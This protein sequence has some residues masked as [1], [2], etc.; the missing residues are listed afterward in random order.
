MKLKQLKWPGLLIAFALGNSP[1]FAAENPNSSSVDKPVQSAIKNPPGQSVTGIKQTGII[2]REK[3]LDEAE[4][5]LKY[6]ESDEAFSLLEPLEFDRSGELRFDYLL[7]VAALESGRPDKATLAFERVLAMNPNFAG[8]R[9]DMARAYFYQEDW[10]RAKSEFEI[11]LTQNPPDATRAIV[12]KYLDTIA[13]QLKAPLLHMTAYA[14]AGLGYDSN[15]RNASNELQFIVPYFNHAIFPIS[16]SN[17]KVADSFYNGALGGEIFY[18]FNDYWSIYAGVDARQR[19][20]QF[21]NNFNSLNFD[22]RAGISFTLNQNIFR[23]GVGGG[24]YYLGQ[25]VGS[26]DSI[27]P[28]YNRYSSAMNADWRYM[29]N[30]DNQISVFIQHANHRFVDT[31]MAIN[32]F[33]Q[34]AVGSG[35]LHVLQDSKS[36]LFASVF[37]ITENDIAP[38]TLTNPNGGR[39]DGAKNLQGIRAGA[40][41][42]V[43]DD[44]ELFSYLSIQS[45]GYENINPLFLLKRNERQYDVSAGANWHWNKHWS[46][47]PQLSFTRN[48]SNIILYS[49]DRLDTSLTIRRDFR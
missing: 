6:D 4:R 2:A 43:Y 41:A 28:D 15:V 1:V 48:D 10:L 8:A 20:Y 46:L 7:G 47:R 45:C 19:G 25:T 42:S 24:A 34:S 16:P 29:L 33:N 3:V 5:L 37:Y 18:D 17:R 11:V 32:D 44:V 36:I 23:I 13:E 27:Q 38:I 12:Q 39:I 9:M 35:W 31:A 30:P 14:E 22:S 26:F 21:L 40:Q 49:Y